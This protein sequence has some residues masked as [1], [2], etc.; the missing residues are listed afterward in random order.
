M[1]D[2]SMCKGEDCPLKNEC[3]RYTATPCE[4]QSYFVDP[5]YIED[6]CEFFYKDLKRDK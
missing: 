1:P 2:I 4:Y 6:E 3:Y 5:P